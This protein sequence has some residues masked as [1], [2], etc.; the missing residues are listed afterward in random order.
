MILS[1]LRVL[2]ASAGKIVIDGIDI[3]NLGLYDLRK[4]ITVIPQV[5]FQH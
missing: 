2:E 1:L 4:K 3:S 5:R